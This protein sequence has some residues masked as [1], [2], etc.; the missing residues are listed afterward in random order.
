MKWK[1]VKQRVLIRFQEVTRNLLHA[2]SEEKIYCYEK[3]KVLNK[4]N[5]LSLKKKKINRKFIT[6]I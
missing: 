4:V 5:Y 3:T 6:S 1:Q 2:S